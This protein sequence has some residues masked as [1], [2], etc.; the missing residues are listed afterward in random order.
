[1]RAA[2]ARTVC[3]HEEALTY[4]GGN[5]YMNEPWPCHFKLPKTSL[6]WTET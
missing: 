2:D 3:L 5:M 4:N 1:M 6:M